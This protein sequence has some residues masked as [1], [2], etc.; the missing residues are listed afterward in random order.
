MEKP[1]LYTDWAICQKLLSPH[2][3]IL[4]SKQDNNEKIVGPKGSN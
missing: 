3:D 2:W 4:F 1:A